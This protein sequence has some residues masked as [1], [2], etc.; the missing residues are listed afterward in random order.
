MPVTAPWTP[1]RQA[2]VTRVP[3]EVRRALEQL[4]L[5][6]C[7]DLFRSVTGNYAH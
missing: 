3:P 4:E 5:L 6:V 2:E 7:V 1:E